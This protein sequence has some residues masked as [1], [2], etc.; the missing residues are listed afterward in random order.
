MVKTLNPSSDS[1]T[2]TSANRYRV[3]IL[4]ASGMLGSTL[5]RSFS[6]DNQFQT[7]GSIRSKTHSD[8]FKVKHKTNII[9]G[10]NVDTEDGL[11]KAFSFA[12][13]DIVINCIGII[14][15][16]PSAHDSLASLSINALLPH[17]IAKLCEVAG[18][19]FIHFSTDCVFSGERGLYTELDYPDASDLYGRSKL[20][21]EVSYDNTITL[22]TSIIG[23]ELTG[24]KSLIDW[25]LNQD[26]EVRGYQKAIFSGLPT[27]EISRVVRNHVIPNSRLNGLYHLSVDPINKYDLL[28]IVSKIYEKDIDIIPDNSVNIDRSLNSDRFQQATGFKKKPWDTLVKNMYLDYRYLK[29]VDT[30]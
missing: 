7:F 24:S 30:D 26:G 16:L 28:S 3:L 29:L 10:I 23:H 27:I 19:R 1:G 5:F 2:V 6:S 22:R 18:S 4:G 15:Q 8:F 13:P 25:F 14:K 21:G 11:L 17:R 9:S 12:R 20:L